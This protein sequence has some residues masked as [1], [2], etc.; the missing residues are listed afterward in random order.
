MATF[1]FKN[2]YETINPKD[3]VDIFADPKWYLHL[4]KDLDEL[5]YHYDPKTASK[6]LKQKRHEFKLIV[7]ELLDNEKI[8]L[9]H[10][11]EN[12][13]AVRKPIDTIVIHHSATAPTVSLQ[14][15]NATQLLRLYAPEHSKPGTKEYGKPIWSNHFYNGKQTFIAYHYIVKRD[16]EI[17]NTLRDDY[18]GWHCGNWDYN[19]R[20]I[21]ICFLD[22]LLDARPSDLAIKSA[23]TIINNYPYCQIL[24]HREI[25]SSRDCPGNLFL[26]NDGWKLELIK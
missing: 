24:G 15:I 26:G 19:C 12:L 16:G 20:S 18:I 7:I 9:A 3:Y 10:D 13:D 11:G 23:K 21:A 5:F 6:K 4:Q 8:A 17:I 25:L 22:D 1:Q 2:H 14:Y